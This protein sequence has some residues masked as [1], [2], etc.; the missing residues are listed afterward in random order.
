LFSFLKNVLFGAD[1]ITHG[2]IKNKNEFRYSIEH[3]FQEFVEL[4]NI[5]DKQN[6]TVK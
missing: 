6:K 5:N 3:K 2:L 1:C 4:N